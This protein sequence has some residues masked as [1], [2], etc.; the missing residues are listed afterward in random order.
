MPAGRK[1]R[2]LVIDDSASVRQTMQ[3]VLEEDPE[4]TVV[5]TAADP[6]SAAR[7]IQ[8]EVPDVITLDVEMPRMDGITFL[9]KLMQQCPVP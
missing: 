7:Y 4:I 6:F 5:A 2:V 1:I 8:D 3:R 9:R